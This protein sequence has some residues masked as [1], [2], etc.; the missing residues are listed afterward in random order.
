MRRDSRF[1]FSTASG[2]AMST[3]HARGQAAVQLEPDA[4]WDVSE[5]GLPEG[6]QI[7]LRE[8]TLFEQY[9]WQSLAVFAALLIQAALILFLLHERYLRRGAKPN[10]GL[11]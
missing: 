8:P 7:R 5:S 4:R 3:G 2:R 10:R 11:V 1:V 9:R 6:S